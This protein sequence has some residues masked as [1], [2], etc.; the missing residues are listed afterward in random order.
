MRERFALHGKVLDVKVGELPVVASCLLKHGEAMVHDQQ[1]LPGQLRFLISSLTNSEQVISYGALMQSVQCKLHSVFCKFS[2]ALG[3]A[4]LL[5]PNLSHQLPG[6]TRLNAISHLY[7]KTDVPTAEAS[8][9]V[10][11]R[12]MGSTVSRAA[13]FSPAAPSM[14]KKWILF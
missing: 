5:Q 2:S 1:Q 14:A 6:N 3:H 8:L 12:P 10:V 4:L 7:V 13:P 11:W 9:A